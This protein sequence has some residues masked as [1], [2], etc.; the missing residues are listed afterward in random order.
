MEENIEAG[1][2]HAP[3]CDLWIMW[4]FTAISRSE[5]CSLQAFEEFLVCI[6]WKWWMH[7]NNCGCLSI[8][9]AQTCCSVTCSQAT[10]VLI[11][12]NSLSTPR[13]RPRPSAGA[14][15]GAGRRARW[16]W[17]ACACRC[18]AEQ[19]EDAQ[20]LWVLTCS[21]EITIGSR[22]EG[23]APDDLDVIRHWLSLQ[24]LL[25]LSQQTEGALTVLCQAFQSLIKRHKY[26]AVREKNYNKKSLEICL[27][28]SSSEHLLNPESMKSEL[29]HKQAEQT[30]WLAWAS[31]STSVSDASRFV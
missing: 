3:S 21:T 22:K 14:Q 2:L 27:I 18:S 12:M 25:G 13:A 24:F 29:K 8:C 23:M 28:T 1:L 20:G 16:P 9:Q 17:A 7:N 11:Q 19:P 15:L 26:T 6:K 5:I 4:C 30:G 31:C 10:S